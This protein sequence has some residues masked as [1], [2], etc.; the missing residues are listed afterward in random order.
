MGFHDW[1]PNKHRQHCLFCT[2]KGCSCR[3]TNSA[4]PPQV[5][6]SRCSQSLLRRG[7]SWCFFL[8]FA[9]RFLRLP[10]IRLAIVDE[11]DVV[12]ELSRLSPMILLDSI[13]IPRCS[14]EVWRM[15]ARAEQSRQR[16][17][18]WPLTSCKRHVKCSS[19]LWVV[20]RVFSVGVRFWDEIAICNC[21]VIVLCDCRLIEEFGC[22]LWVGRF[23]WRAETVFYAVLWSL[24]FELYCFNFHILLGCVSCDGSTRYAH[25]TK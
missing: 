13:S 19:M 6:L 10:P 9:K 5:K 25:Y 23:R 20:S 21:N 17:S 15:W 3:G 22:K 1:W 7:G 4:L 2:S 12:E 16:D 18:T 24:T 8:S 11:V 14:S